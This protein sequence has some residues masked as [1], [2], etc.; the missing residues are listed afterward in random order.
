MALLTACS[1]KL[2]VSDNPQP[3]TEPHAVR[4]KELVTLVFFNFGSSDK[5]DNHLSAYK[6][7]A[8]AF[9]DA[10]EV[11]VLKTDQN[12][13]LEF[14]NYGYF[15]FHNNGT[16]SRQG[17][18]LSNGIDKPVVVTNPDNYI[19]TY[20]S[21]FGV[22]FNDKVY[23]SRM[24]KA[25]IATRQKAAIATLEKKFKVDQ[26]Y[27]AQL[28]AHSNTSFY[29]KNP[30]NSR[31]LTGKVT[32]RFYEDSARTKKS[33]VRTE[34]VYDENGQ[35]QRYTMFMNDA[36]FS[37]DIYYRNSYHLIDSIVKTD[38]NG[39]R[40]ATV[41]K[42]GKDRFS[43]VSVDA[44]NMMISNVFQLN[45]RFQCVR[46]ETFN[47]S[48]DLVGASSFKYDTLGRVIEETGATQ[49]I[50]YEYNGQEEFYA[51]MRI[52]GA[53][54]GALLTENI[55]QQGKDRLLMVSKNDGRVSSRSI[56]FMSPDG[57]IK[58]AYNYNGNDKITEVYEYFYGN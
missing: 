25:E 21:Y 33:P 34:T 5:L 14:E 51:V 24:R 18:I 37:E 7:F 36:L 55:R 38:N 27:A 13:V 54:D 10:E 40:S 8:E 35:L 6:R 29:P 47:G 31:C 58:T 19:K 56:S 16:K 45:D 52:Y 23:Y 43:I 44:K 48:G 22:P 53:P 15:Y 32:V 50:R 26:R 9:K 11:L 49:R 20:E 12:E 46:K 28:A 1:P 17:M 57:C 42:Y 39:L 3:A 41:F 4:N 2:I 30:G